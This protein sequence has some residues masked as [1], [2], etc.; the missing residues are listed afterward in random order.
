MN[1]KLKVFMGLTAAV[2]LLLAGATAAV[3]APGGKA[4]DHQAERMEARQAKKGDRGEHK[5]AR[6][7]KADKNGDGFLTRDEVGEKRWQHISKADAN[8]DQKVSKAELE[9]ARKNGQLGKKG[10]HKKGDRGKRKGKQA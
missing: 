8:K 1:R 2:G 10:K 6:F 3:A 9:Q 4:K 5:G 7:A